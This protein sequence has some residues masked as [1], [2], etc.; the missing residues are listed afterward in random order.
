MPRSPSQR[1]ALVALRY[2]LVRELRVDSQTIDWEA[3]DTAL[4]RQVV[5]QLLRPELAQDPTA[6]EQFW[7]DARA[8]AHRTATVGNRVLDA[9]TDPETGRHFVVREW[10]AAPASAGDGPRLP[11]RE[12]AVLAQQLSRFDG[13]PR[14]LVPSGVAIVLI[15]L[16]TAIK[17]G[18]D[19]WLAW[20]NTPL[21]RLDRSFGLAPAVAVPA[22]GAQPGQSTSTPAPAPPTVAAAARSVPPAATVA[23]ASPPRAATA[24]AP[25]TGQTRRVVNTDGRGVALRAAPGAD[26]LPG[27]GYDEGATVQALEQS[28]E[29]TRIRG[30]DGREGW[31]LSVTLAP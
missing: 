16:A 20:V 2:E 4:E 30:S 18:V 6:T 28:G 24:T 10:P 13:R 17:P 7:Q 19:G 26:R 8:A 31:V 29:W 25:S 21:A 9:G 14:W 15:L 22:S 27:K 1:V 23:A 3:F 12:P 5:V 11:P